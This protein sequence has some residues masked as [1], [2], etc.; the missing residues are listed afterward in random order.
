[1]PEGGEEALTIRGAPKAWPGG[2]CCS[3]PPISQ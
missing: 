2:H 1:M 3:L